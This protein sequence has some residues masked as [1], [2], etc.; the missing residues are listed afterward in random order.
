[1]LIRTHLDRAIASG[2]ALTAQITTA[3]AI[4]RCPARCL[5]PFGV[6]VTFDQFEFAI[7]ARTYVALIRKRDVI[8]KCRSQQHVIVTTFER[9]ISA[10][11]RDAMFLV[12]HKS[13][14]H[15]GV[16]VLFAHFLAVLTKNHIY[17]NELKIRCVA[18]A[19]EAAKPCYKRLL[20]P[21]PPDFA[22][23]KRIPI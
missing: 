22:R 2:H 15:V 19:C 7:T 14:I 4:L 6:N 9:L 10:G 8:T 23:I 11:E 18:N 13:L 20:T 3:F 12:I 21:L 5:G 16:F 17:F 1:V